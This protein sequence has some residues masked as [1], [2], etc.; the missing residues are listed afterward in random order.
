MQICVQL[1]CV[2]HL[3]FNEFREH[4]S[5]HGVLYLADMDQEKIGNA[6]LR[7]AANRG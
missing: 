1:H 4:P 3:P 6:R 7:R 2:G 5:H